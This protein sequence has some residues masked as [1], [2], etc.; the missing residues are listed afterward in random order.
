MNKL[1]SAE[2][3]HI[4]HLL[5][6]GNSIRAITRLTGT[7]KVTVTKLLIDAGKACAAYHDEQVRG[8]K[9]NRT[10]ATKLGRST[11]ANK[12]MLRPPRPR[13]LTRRHLDLDRDRRRQQADRELFGGRPRWRSA[14]VDGR[15]ASRLA[16]RVSARRRTHA[17]TWRP[18]RARSA[19]DVDYAQVIKLYG[20]RLEAAGPLQPRRM[21]RGQEGSHRGQPRQ[22]TSA[23]RLS[24]STTRRCGCTCAASHA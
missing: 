10:K 2:R 13:R 21:H 11:I 3:A 24:S 16:N 8:V 23:R 18:W 12:R 19:D 1:N 14:L 9:A 17:R 6:E 5:C 7:S 20:P 4:L 15:S 22:S